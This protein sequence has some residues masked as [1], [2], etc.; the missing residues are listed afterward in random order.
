MSLRPWSV[1]LIALTALAGDLSAQRPDGTGPRPAV[2]QGPRP[3]PKFDLP[4]QPHFMVPDAEQ[5]DDFRHWLAGKMPK[6]PKDID[7]KVLKDFMDQVGRMPNNK[8]PD[9][10]QIEDLLKSNPKFQDPAFLKQLQ[11][12]V[13]SKDFPG[14]LQQK[15]NQQPGE[16]PVAVPP[17]NQELADKFKQVIEGAK[18]QT[19]PG[20]PETGPK[21]PD[22]GPKPPD[23]KPENMPKLDPA[24]QE[25]AKWAQK[26]FGDSPALQ[27]AI[28]ELGSSLDGPDGKG[29]IGDIPELK[30]DLFKHLDLKGSPGE[31]FKIRPPDM[32]T[33][34]WAGPKIG[35]TGGGGPSLGGGPRRRSGG[36]TPCRTPRPV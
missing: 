26:N 7:P 34:G 31:S 28:K 27:D 13:E 21:G 17:N 1:P 8:Q 23:L 9:P 10:K 32:D 22:E 3:Q 30:G 11:Q 5:V 29:L 4:P 20:G 36:A 12:M 18:E 2:K 14:N 25:L 6:A 35:E 19:G 33:G 16:P 15:L 24:E